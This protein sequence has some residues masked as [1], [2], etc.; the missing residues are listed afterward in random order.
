MPYSELATVKHRVIVGQPLPFGVRNADFTLLL[1]RGQVIENHDQLEALMSRGAVVDIQ[2]LL[3]ESQRVQMASPQ[4]L[5][6]LWQRCAAQLAD[7]LQQGGAGEAFKAALE[8]AAVPAMALIER[9]PDLAIFQV[10]R[11]DQ[12]ELARYG[13]DHSMHAG[14]TSVL[15][16]RRL[17]WS[18]TDAQRAFKAALTMNIS[19][20]ELQG[21]LATQT[22]PMTREQREAMHAHPWFSTRMLEIA[23]VTDPDWLDAVATHHDALE[24]ASYPASQRNAN[25]LAALIRRADI[26]VAKLSPR[27]G[28]RA[29]PADQ[30]GR[31]LFRQDPKNPM[32]A[33]LVKEFGVYPPGC[34]VRLASG[35]T[36][37]VLRRGATVIAP[38]VAVLTSASGQ[39][40]TDPLPRDTSNPAHAVQSL[41][42][43]LPEFASVA[44]SVL[45]ALAP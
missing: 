20:L 21:E 16:A 45:A 8:A 33:A 26:Y 10:L 9:D 27:A 13:M 42:P 35:E 25:E 23:G 22:T 3:T 43:D 1:A 37:V 18:E 41:L 39:R 2:E 11:Q 38:M 36:G 17:G 6:A 44:Q 4:E 29:L 12:N 31:A 14:I 7:T 30:A 28:R 24:G 5:P 19:M 32:T 40:L 34:F 15:V